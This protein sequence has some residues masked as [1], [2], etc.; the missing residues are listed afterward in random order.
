MHFQPCARLVTSFRGLV[1]I[2]LPLAALALAVGAAGCA[3]RAEPIEKQQLAATFPT[4]AAWTPVP[5]AGAGISD[6]LA[7]GMNNGREIVGS[8][9]NA[10]VYIYTDGVDFFVRLRV[11]DD[12][13]QGGTVRPFG[14]GLLIDTNN[15]FA[16]YEFA[17]M[18]DGT[19]NPKSVVLSQN[20][21]PGTT[22]DPSGRDH[23]QHD[24]REPRPGR[25]RPDHAS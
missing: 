1:R 11:D 25:K 24:A 22:G 19:G 5:Q 20:T 4:T 17:L 2:R 13:A 15:D 18:V 6:P 7:D 8:S 12:P 10:A 23:P 3:Q 14:W 16:A 21:T 9:T